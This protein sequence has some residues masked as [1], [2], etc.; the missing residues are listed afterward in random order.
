MIPLIPEYIH[1]L[2]A[3][4]YFVKM[5]QVY[6]DYERRTACMKAIL[7]ASK[8]DFFK[9]NFNNCGL[10]EVLLEIIQSGTKVHLDL[11]EQAFNILSNICKDNRENQKEFR[12]KG[13]IEYRKTNLAYSEV[14]QSGNAS[15]FLLS[16]IDCLS[17]A[18]FG[19]KR[20]ELHFLD[21][22]GVYVLLDLAESCEQSLKRLCLSAI[23]TIL[24]NPKS[25]QYFVEWSSS[26]STINASQLLVKLY[27]EEDKRFGVKM[28]NGIL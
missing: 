25:F 22:E 17:N 4:Q 5:M 13:G 9:A 15:T 18:V 21:I 28:E 20:C 26:R 12:R 8:F 19:N 24:E 14:E 10:I 7:Q 3:H 23:C 16:V 2:N 27:Q 11:R 1:S 6:T